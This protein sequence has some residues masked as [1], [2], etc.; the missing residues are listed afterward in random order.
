MFSLT[1]QSFLIK[2]LLCR[3]FWNQGAVMPNSVEKGTAVL[4]LKSSQLKLCFCF[5]KKKRKKSQTQRRDAPG[6][7]HGRASPGGSPAASV[8]TRPCPADSSCWGHQGWMLCSSS[9]SLETLVICRPGGP[10]EFPWSPSAPGSLL[11]GAPMAP[12]S[13]STGFMAT[14]TVAAK[15]FVDGDAPWEIGLAFEA[16]GRPGCRS[17]PARC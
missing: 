17:I 12:A 6:A 10:P 9:P 7:G 15:P 11:L 3:I 13:L 5:G 1:I 16:E 4:W 14:W 8:C 2:S